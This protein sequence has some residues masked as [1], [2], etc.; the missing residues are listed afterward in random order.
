MLLL[1]RKSRICSKGV[2]P[3]Y[4]PLCFYC[5]ADSMSL[6]ALLISYLHSIMLLLYLKRMEVAYMTDTYLHSIMLLLY[7]NVRT[8]LEHLKST[9]TFHY[10]STVSTRMAASIANELN[11]HSIMLLLYHSAHTSYSIRF[12]IYIPLCFYCLE[13]LIC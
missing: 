7:Q 1:Y 4:I 2:K 10:A 12:N 6:P 5:I 13:V 11:L 3:I 8:A 9:F